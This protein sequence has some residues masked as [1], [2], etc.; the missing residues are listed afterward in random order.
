MSV[1][2][3][4][5]YLNF[6]LKLNVGSHILVVDPV[7]WSKLRHL[8]PSENWLDLFEYSLPVIIAIFQFG[9][10]SGAMNSRSNM[11]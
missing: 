6:S 4:L 10:I 7:R 9:L 11:L 3:T 5:A 2:I 8:W 1:L